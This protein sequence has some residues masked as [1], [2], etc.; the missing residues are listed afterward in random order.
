[1]VS[2]DDDKSFFW[3]VVVV[4][5]AVVATLL[6]TLLH[7]PIRKGCEGGGE[8]G[9]VVEDLLIRSVE[10]VVCYNPCLLAVVGG[11]IIIFVG[12]DPIDI[13]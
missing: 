7:D 6:F 11:Q 4:V 10:I 3:L 13:K 8:R 9:R 1:L 2:D 12:F 5:V